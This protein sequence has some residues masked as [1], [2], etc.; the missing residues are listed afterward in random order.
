M[1]AR[2]EAWSEAAEQSGRMDVEEGGEEELSLQLSNER[3][4]PFT[5]RDV[6]RSVW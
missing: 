5:H 1:V 6:K 3:L 4:K 2:F